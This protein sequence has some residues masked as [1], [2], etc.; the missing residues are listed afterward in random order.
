MVIEDDRRVSL[1][2]GL[3]DADI[4]C[5]ACGRVEEALDERRRAATMTRNE[6]ERALLFAP[7]GD[8]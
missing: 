4:C 3:D 1:T 2:E 8:T 5:P 7:G 6:R